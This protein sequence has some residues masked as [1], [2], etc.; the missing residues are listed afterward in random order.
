MTS[1]LKRHSD[2]EFLRSRLGMRRVRRS[3][4]AWQ[5]GKHCLATSRGS[6]RA[7]WEASRKTELLK[8]YP[9]RTT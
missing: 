9:P 2:S 8:D 5:C 1:R 7:S 3:E 6:D 4:S